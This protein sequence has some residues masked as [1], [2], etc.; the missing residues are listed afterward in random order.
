MGLNP[1]GLGV[2]PFLRALQETTDAQR[3]AASSAGGQTEA[4]EPMETDDGAEGSAEKGE[5]ME[6]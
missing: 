6:E 5:K 2:E 1:A 4:A 3:A